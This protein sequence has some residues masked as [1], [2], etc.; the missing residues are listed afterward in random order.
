M[1]RATVT[2]APGVLLRGQDGLDL[3]ATGRAFV[4]AL[5]PVLRRE[6]PE[7]EALA[8]TADVGLAAHRIEVDAADPRVAQRLDREIRDRIWVVR[9]MVPFAVTG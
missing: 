4:A 9:E 5:E 3:A 2:I 1:A 6:L 8:I 7:L